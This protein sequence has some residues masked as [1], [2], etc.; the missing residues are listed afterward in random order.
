MSEKIDR[1]VFVSQATILT[2]A[3]AA[4][5]FPGRADARRKPKQEVVMQTKI[6]KGLT[7]DVPWTFVSPEADLGDPAVIEKYYL[8][9]EKQT[10]DAPAQVEAW[11]LKWSELSAAVSEEEAI[12]YIKMTCQTDDPGREAAFLHFVEKVSPRIKPLSHRL[13][14]K[15]LAAPGLPGL[16]ADRYRVLLRDIKNDVELYRDENVPLQT[17]EEKLSQKYQKVTGGMTVQY[18]GEERTLQQMARYYEVPDRS[19]RQSAWETVARRR[20]QDRE[21]LDRIFDDMRALRAEMA[22]NSGFGNYRDYNL[23]LRGRFDYGVPESEAF[24]TAVEQAVV[25]LYRELQER[26]RRRMKLDRLRPWDLRPDPFG[27]PPLKPFTTGAELAAGCQKI[28]DDLDPELGRRF[29]FLLDHE[30][31]D[32]ESR[33][34]KAPGAY[35]HSLGMLRLPFIFANS[36]GVDGDVHTLLHEC[37]HAFHTLEAREEPLSFYRHAPLE[38]AEVASMG[39]EFLGLDGTAV[40]YGPD[41]LARSRE[42]YLESIVGLFCWIATVDAFQ[43][44]IYTHPGH[45]VSDREDAWMDLRRRFGGIEDWSGYEE[46]RRSEWHRQ[47]HIFEMPFYYIE[48]GIAQLGALQVWQKA[49]EDKAAALKAYRGALKLGGSRPLPELF[50]AAGLKFDFSRATVEPLVRHVKEV[51]DRDAAAQG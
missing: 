22:A 9:L 23:R 38:F 15:L 4:A 6:G 18:D 7:Y 16:D 34:G 8:E 37:G 3:A 10:L 46:E 31:M 29:K 51:L 28:F 48:Y 25:P 43:H 32:L 39:M 41:E 47:L 11:L 50:A 42:G 1:R 36:V 19:V 14:K 30:L 13:A 20:L 12:R 26:R 44:W 5:F 40:F 27:R 17:E 2:G 33:K 21:E 24:H 49:T 35:S 45:T